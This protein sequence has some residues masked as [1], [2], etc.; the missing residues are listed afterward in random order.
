LL[1]IQLLSGEVAT[2]SQEGY[3][4]LARLQT[5][6]EI[7]LFEIQEELL[8]SL[9]RELHPC[10]LAD[11]QLRHDMLL[12]LSL[13]L[14]RSHLEHHEKNPYLG[15]IRS[16]YQHVLQAV[17]Q[18][19]A[20]LGPAIPALTEDDEG[21][22]A[23][24]VVSAIERLQVQKLYRVVVACSAGLAGARLLT[25]RLHSRLPELEVVDIVSVLDLRHSTASHAAIDAIISTVPLHYSFDVPV[26]VISPFLK[27]DELESIREFFCLP[28]HEAPESPAAAEALPGLLDVLSEEMVDVNVQTETWQ[29]VVDIS[30]RPLLSHAAIEAEYVAAIK[31]L[32]GEY[33]PYMVLW[34]HVVLLHAHPEDG[35]RG[36]SLSMM[37]LADPV[38][39][40][41]LPDHQVTVAATLATTDTRSHLQL[42]DDLRHVFSHPAFLEQAQAA[43][44]KAD[45]MNV[46]SNL[47]AS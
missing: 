46:L 9:S 17:D 27:Q 4:R 3:K 7:D 47:M 35:A 20:Q 24:L 44:G 31:D 18:A 29:Q 26:L 6:L 1:A 15:Q 30:C 19:L 41:P 8:I 28:T 36:L 34:P 42:L 33:G 43:R 11:K 5:S 10:L 45:L 12:Q 37:T 38:P 32:L 39:F 25:A 23:M 21:Y 13:A 16:R 22:L 40:G 2:S 14:N